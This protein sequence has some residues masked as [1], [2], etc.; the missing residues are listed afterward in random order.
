[1][2]TAQHAAHNQD[3][4]HIEDDDHGRTLVVTGDW[5]EAA[6]NVLRTGQVDGLNLNYAK[7]Y[8][9]RSLEF[10]EPWPITRLSILT[11]TLTNIEPVYRLADSLTELNLITSPKALLECGRLPNLQTLSVENWNQIRD[12]LDDAP[13]LQALFVYA[14]PERDLYPLIGH[15]KLTSLRMKPCP[16]LETLDGLSAFPELT[17]LQVVGAK[18]LT[19]LSALREGHPKLTKLDLMAS[20]NIGRL[21]DLQNLTGLIQLNIAECRHVASLAPLTGMT[22]LEDL[23]AW[24]STRIDDGDLSPLLSLSRLSSLYM[25]ERPFYAPSVSEVKQSLGIAD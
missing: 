23:F 24:A 20:S 8:R 21:D 14:Y 5:S 4:F 1:M 11:R 13:H 19:D 22:R 17:H 2:T 12:S 6:A 10:L 25:K 16:R 18:R 7:G 15:D 3:G 9:E